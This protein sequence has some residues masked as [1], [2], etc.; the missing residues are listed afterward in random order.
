MERNRHMR[1]ACAI[2][3]A[4]I[5]GALIDAPTAAR[6]DEG[7]VSF[8]IPGFYSSLAAAPLEPG[9]ALTGMEY[10]DSGQGRRRCRPGAQ[11]YHPCRR[12]DLQREATGEHQRQPQCD[13]QPRR[14]YS[15]PTP[16]SSAS[17]E[18]RRRSECSTRLGYVDTT[19][20]GQISGSA[21]AV[22]LFEIRQHHRSADRR[23][24]FD[25]DPSAALECRRAQL[26][27]LRHRRSSRRTI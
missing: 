10:F 11:R 18:P 19:L 12:H 9:W 20:Q 7:G 26:P 23:R 2:G 8:W 1:G 5:L 17:S 27:A 16:S 6:A 21:R 24:R 15:R 4:L 25:P 22:R 13:D 14:R 3:C